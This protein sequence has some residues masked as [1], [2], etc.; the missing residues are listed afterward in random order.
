MLQKVKA[1]VDLIEL[2]RNE[3]DLYL[4]ASDH[5]LIA[6]VDSRSDIEGGHSVQFIFAAAN[7]H[8]FDAETEE[9][10]R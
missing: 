8:F 7:M 3:R 6:R 5:E 1:A 4:R 10:I 2:L 9:A